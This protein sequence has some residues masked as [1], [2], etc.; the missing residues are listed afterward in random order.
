MLPHIHLGDR[1]AVK[2][3]DGVTIAYCGICC[4]HCGMRERIPRMAFEL[5]R[6]VDA[7]GY[8]Q[9]IRNVTSDF[10]FDNFFAG[11][12]WFARSG[13]VG[14]LRGGGMPNCEVRDCCSHKDLQNC[15]SCEEFASCD[16][17]HY[18]KQTYRISDRYAQIVRIGYANW[19]QEQKRKTKSGFDNIEYLEE[20][21]GQVP[22]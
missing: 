12:K 13:C 6:F 1:N 10:D 21:E 22:Q 4:E 2:R 19:V 3:N 8:S 14:C 20:T 11:L 17:T 15:Y 16:K 9:W 18:Q 7:Y 5:R